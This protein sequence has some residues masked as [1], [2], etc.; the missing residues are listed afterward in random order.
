M[1]KF[2]SPHAPGFRAVSTDIRQWVIE[3]PSLI[4]RRWVAEECERSARMQNEITERMS[5]FVGHDAATASSPATRPIPPSTPAPPYA[6]TSA[7]GYN[8]EGYTTASRAVMPASYNAVDGHYMTLAQ[9]YKLSSSPSFAASSTELLSSS[10]R[11]STSSTISVVSSAPPPYDEHEESPASAT[12]VQATHRRDSDM[13][14]QA[15]ARRGSEMSLQVPVPS[16]VL[17]QFLNQQNMYTM[18]VDGKLYLP[19]HSI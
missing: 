13:C 10:R 6:P 18:G 5:P 1:C 2:D 7:T 4:Q 9:G 3:A 15:T 19:R 8:Q 17:E 16:H 14:L 11:P 12:P